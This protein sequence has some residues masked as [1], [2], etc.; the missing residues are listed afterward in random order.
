MRLRAYFV[1]AAIALAA[2]CGA[3]PPS[4]EDLPEP[5]AGALFC[6]FTAGA[7]YGELELSSTAHRNVAVLGESTPAAA[8]GAVAV[9]SA[10]YRILTGYNAILH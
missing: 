7:A 8:N 10:H 4:V 5:D 9:E 3:P 6:A 1:G 2:A